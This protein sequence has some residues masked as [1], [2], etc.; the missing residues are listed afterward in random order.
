MLS[1]VFA[2][3]ITFITFIALP[4]ATAQQIYSDQEKPVIK[5]GVLRG[6]ISASKELPKEFYGSWYVYGILVDTDNEPLFKSRI[7]DIW[8]LS[9]NTDAM[10][11]NDVITLTNPVSGATSSIS[12]QEVK[13]NT[14]IFK[15]E[16]ITSFQKEYETAK[17]TI[18]GDSFTG[19]DTQVFEHYR[20]GTLI[21]KDYAKYEVKGNKK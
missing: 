21:R 13:G 3:F 14:A 10:S 7:F 6:T 15:R 16:K 1:L 9:K 12:I 2:L 4:V 11:K 8:L 19:T 20:Y 18:N 17:I 5:N